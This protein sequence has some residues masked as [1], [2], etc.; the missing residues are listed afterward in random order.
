M[1]G[2]KIGNS[3]LKYGLFLAP[4]AGVSDY[5]F[6]QVS[7]MCGAEYTVSEMVSAKA[8][9][10]EMRIRK[11]DKSLA[12]TAPLAFVD[13]QSLPHA[14]QI[15][16]CESKFMAEAARLIEGCAY[17]GCDSECPPTAID[18][19]MG[20]PVNKVVSNG[21]GSALMK[22]PSLV[23]EIVYN[24]V[25]AVNI[26]VTV[27]IRAGWDSN[28]KNAIEIAKI[29]EESGAAAVFVHGRTK[30]QMYMGHVDYDIIAKVKQNVSVPVIGNGDIYS[31]SDAIKMLDYTKCDGIMVARGAL[32]NPWIFSEIIANLE[33]ELF[34]PP[35]R[36]QR[37]IIIKAQIDMMINQKGEKIA[38]SEAKKHL[39]WYT[40]GYEGAANLRAKINNAQ[41]IDE[42]T[43]L[44]WGR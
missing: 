33:N 20:C 11:Q 42:M 27:K 16:G 32:G 36:K 5:A 2:L 6:R 37:E 9:C 12:R 8:L 15:F 21:E 23:G 34:I 43:K 10:Y 18:I 41:T 39:S 28:S 14:V 19:N 13:K 38:A 30:D 26:P 25:R 40:K 3:K 1:S 7:K 4:L 29:A 44:L 22:S 35:N 31:A 17:F 24:V